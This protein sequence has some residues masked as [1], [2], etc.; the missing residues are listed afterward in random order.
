MDA[1]LVRIDAHLQDQLVILALKVWMCTG[2]LK[3]LHTYVVHIRLGIGER[4][5]GTIRAIDAEA[6][7]EISKS[8]YGRQETQ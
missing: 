3:R 7:P 6:E 5:I 2:F 4:H 1:Q 8:E